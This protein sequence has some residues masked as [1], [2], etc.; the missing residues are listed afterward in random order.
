M[1]KNKFPMKDVKLY[2]ILTI[3]C[4]LVFAG[5][6]S[7]PNQLRCNIGVT[8]IT[9]EE[10]VVLAGFAAREGLSTSIHRPLKTHCIVIENDS[11]RV[12]I[13][14]NDMM[15]ISI[16]MASELRD[17]IA[18]QTG[19]PRDHI[20]IHCTHTHSAPRAGGSSTEKG[21]TNYAFAKKFRETVVMNA[22]QT[23]NNKKAFIPFTIETGKGES[24]INCNRREKDGPCDHDVY[25]AH[26]LEKK[27]KPIVS[28]LNFACHPVSLNHRSLVVSPDFPGITAEELSKEWGN[29][30]FYF[31]GAAGNVDPCGALKADTS[32]TQEKGMQLADAVRNIRTEKIKKAISF[33]L[34]IWR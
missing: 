15:E 27:G 28:L 20:F 25:L 26:F 22:M 7:S 18:A 29:D 10:P 31:S 5:C 16:N 24:H 19:I 21:G 4:V 2:I 9:P 14:S 30:L 33:A 6:S 13:I 34:A 1:V 8:T 23:A 17:E 32:Y 11:V 12:C 3:V